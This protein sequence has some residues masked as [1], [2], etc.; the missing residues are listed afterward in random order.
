MHD[1]TNPA[2]AAASGLPTDALAARARGADPAAF[3]EL[4]RRVAPAIHAWAT[5]QIRPPMRR[6]LDPDDL[7]QEVTCRAWERFATWDEAKG[8]FRGWL[9]GIAR[10]VLREAFRRAASA[11]ALAPRAAGDSGD[12][13]VQVPDSA[14]AVSR[15]LARDEGL[16]ALIAHVD[17]LPDEERKLLLWRG[18]EGLPHAEVA[19]LLQASPDAVAKR[20]Q[21]LR[22]ALRDEPRLAEILAA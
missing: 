21:R 4:Y 1:A 5:L 10:N 18:I 15:A 2:S 22:D 12:A 16:A 17:A 3:A 7:L 20:W 11:P 8:P 19:Q 9:F 13:F 6:L 14:T